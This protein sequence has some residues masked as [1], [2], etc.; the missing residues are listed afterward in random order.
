MRKDDNVIPQ[1]ADV[2][3]F[4]TALRHPK[5]RTVSIGPQSEADAREMIAL[6]DRK[7]RDSDLAD[8]PLSGT[9]GLPSP[10]VEVETEVFGS[11]QSVHPRYNGHTVLVGQPG[12]AD[13]DPSA[14]RA[15][16]GIRDE[17][18]FSALE[19]PRVRYDVEVVT[20]LVVYAGK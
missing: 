9:A 2:T 20:K 19:K 6:R 1:A 4:F 15:D 8:G 3:A 10:L 18:M 13:S 12:A 11:K 16:D 7:R 17:Q 14:S 5:K